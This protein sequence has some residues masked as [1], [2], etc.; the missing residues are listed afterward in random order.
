MVSTEATARAFRQFH[1]QGLLILTNV[2][3]AGTA[4]LVESVGARALATTSAGV[5]WSHGYADGDFLPVRLLAATVSDITRATR[6][7]LS[8]D[9]EG[10]YASVPVEVGQAV[11]TILDVGA[12][13]I[14]LEDGSGAPDLL[15]AKI[16]QAKRAAVRQ[17]VDLFVNA[18]TDVYLRGLVPEE[19]RVQE[20][21]ARAE[22]Y[23]SA[24]ADGIFVPGVTD[25]GDIRALTTAI[26]L[27]VNVLARPGLPL[28]PELQALGVR[29]LSTGARITEAVYGRAAALAAAFL[30]DGASDRLGEGAMPYPEVNA[31]F[32]SR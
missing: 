28:A 29:R 14:N 2:W 20:T 32:T 16:E 6:V 27:P 31:L 26:P 12:V 11:A 15:C 7:P 21:V 24:G 3:D 17:G 4:R 18:R 13:G 30:H 1:E 25:R 5:A 10:G 9:M 22:R 8:V 23:R 19:L